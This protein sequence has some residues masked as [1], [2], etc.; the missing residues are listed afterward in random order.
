MLQQ[1]DL[2]HRLRTEASAWLTMTIVL[3]ALLQVGELLVALA[4]ELLVADGQHL[5]DEQ[6]VGVDVDR[7]REARAARTCPT[8]S[9]SPACR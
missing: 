5:V 2:S 7:D 6:D 8:S 4:L 3:P 9:S 1:R